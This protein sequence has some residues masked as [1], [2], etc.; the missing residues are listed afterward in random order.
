MRI[1]GFNLSLRLSHDLVNIR[2]KTLYSTSLTSPDKWESHSCTREYKMPSEDLH[3]RNTEMLSH[4]LFEAAKI[5]MLIISP[6][7]GSIV[8]AN[9]AAINYYGYTHI[10][11]RH[12]RVSDLNQLSEE[13]TLAEMNRAAEQKRCHF[14][15]VHRLASGELR[16]VEV[17]SG[18][19]IANEKQ[20]LYSV[21]HDITNRRA[22]EKKLSELNRDFITLLDNTSDFIYFKDIDSRFRFCSQTLARITGHRSWQEMKGKHDLEVF[23]ADTA[24]IYYEE[25]RPIFEQG[26]AILN[27]IDPYYDE[28]GK[29]C[30]VSTNKWPVFDEKNKV[31]G[32]F[33]ISRDVTHIQETQKQLQIAASV[34]ENVNEGLMIT[35]LEGK[36]VQVNN[37]FCEL[38]G[39]QEDEV[40]GKTPSFLT[41][42]HH[43]NVFFE[44]MWNSLL[45]QQSW[46]GNIW[47]RHKDG[48]LFA[49]RTSINCVRD[50]QGKTTNFVGV[51][52]D[53]TAQLKHFEEVEKMAYYDTLTGL[54]NRVLL[55]DRM[56]QSLRQADRNKELVGVCF[57]DLDK[58][59]L[60]ND[61]Y[62][63]KVG[64]LLL[65]EVAQRIQAVLRE[66]DTVAR[67]S[68]DEFALVL[69]GLTA[70]SHLE[71]VVN[72]ILICLKKPY[73]LQGHKDIDIS[74]SIGICIYPNHRANGEQLLKAADA[75]MYQAK[76]SGRNKYHLCTLY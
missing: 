15:F 57:L 64:D 71:E 23:P 70:K 39:Y 17:H 5:P 76:K 40:I 72:L 41:S 18:P 21:I 8:D 22:T 53:I 36:I 42:G 68:G 35:D 55:N 7:D 1:S 27:K 49:S 33:G 75:A 31:T 43:D 3:N 50:E 30:W 9:Q 24:A 61:T 74:A 54:P 52:T 11:F 20:Y 48:G 62:G 45:Q 65:I 60:V 63:H 34:F 12:L 46:K 28:S 32:L 56:S 44:E 37:A 19:M 2:P 10:Q 25:E 29:T 47:N 4:Q 69:T 58:F 16:D 66:R 67:L 14:F 26:K 6:E 73:E 38:S 59:K 51:F 13:E